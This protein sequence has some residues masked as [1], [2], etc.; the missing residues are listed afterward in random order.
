MVLFK[1]LNEGELPQVLILLPLK[2]GIL[3]PRAE[4]QFPVSNLE[5][6]SSISEAMKGDRYIGVVQLREDLNEAKPDPVFRCGCVGRI[7]DLQ[8]NDEGQLMFSV[9][10]ICR[11]EI[12][13]ELPA[14]K[15]CRRVLVSYDK[16]E[17]DIVHEADFT[18][19]RDRLISAL[20]I[21]CK[22]LRIKPNWKELDRTSNERLVTMLMMICPFDAHEKQALLETVGY[23]AQSKLVTSLIEMDTFAHDSL[24]YH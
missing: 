6:L 18:F 21:Y 7:H 10:G 4:L 8:E 5:N 12:K 14:Y 16:Y 17:T 22:K 3:I 23:A 11:F 19:D 13:Q 15:A 2:G 20:K 1:S 9:C 24:M